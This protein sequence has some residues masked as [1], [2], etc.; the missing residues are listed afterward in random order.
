MR[1]T[2]VKK[3]LLLSGGND[4]IGLAMAEAWLSQGNLASVLDIRTAN[5]EK[6]QEQFPDALRIAK[7]DM[8]DGGAV[9]CAV[10]E[11]VKTFGHIDCAVHNACLCLFKSFEEHTDEDYGDVMD[12]NFKGARNLT[13]AVLPAMLKAKQGRIFYTSSGVGV[14][15]FVNLSAYC[16]SK[17]AIE[18]F[19]KCMNLEYAKTGVSFHILQPPLTDTKSSAP[20]PVPKEFKASAKKVGEGLARRL[21][22]NKFIITPSAADAFSVKLSYLF[23][24]PMGRL[25][26]K[27]TANSKDSIKN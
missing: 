20:L 2:P 17:G 22:R 11:A 27:M 18:A 9:Q 15:G 26:T 23:A 10:D 5:L 24:L 3:V 13:L 25:L 19:A 14:T 8:R 1:E 16:A 21:Y 6:L 7:C 12:V 4:G